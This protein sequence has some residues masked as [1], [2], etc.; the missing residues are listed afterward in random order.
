MSD[1]FLKSLGYIDAELIDECDEYLEK[2]E[3]KNE[4]RKKRRRIVIMYKRVA[5]LFVIS[6]VMFGTVIGVHLR[7][8]RNEMP[9]YTEYR[10][11][12]E[13]DEAIQVSTLLSRMPGADVEMVE[14]YNHTVTETET[15]ADVVCY[16]IGQNYSFEL[17]ILFTQ[18]NVPEVEKALYLDSI[19]N[20]P[21]RTTLIDSVLVQYSAFD[22]G[23]LMTDNS[24]MVSVF[25]YDNMYYQFIYKMESDLNT[26][27]SNA[28]A[29]LEILLR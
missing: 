16:G 3:A 19:P 7:N 2:L 1:F 14:V 8:I 21:L 25:L 23:I 4:R 17:D 26:T 11:F 29:Y 10:S 12:Q 18:R 22:N 28:L 6:F 20:V 5:A 24:V 15:F 9:V 13:A 27:I